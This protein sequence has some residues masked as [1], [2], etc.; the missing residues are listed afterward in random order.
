[1][2]Y[3]KNYLPLS[4]LS[5]LSK[6]LKRCVFVQMTNYLEGNQLLNLSPHGFRATHSSV[7]AL[8][9]MYES[10]IE[11]FEDDEVSAVI[12]LDMTTAFNV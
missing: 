11:A 8:I 12:M 1:M 6:V 3:P 4:L 9:Q 5:F 7:S 10:W 2:L